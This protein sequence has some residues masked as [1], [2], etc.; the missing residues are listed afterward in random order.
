MSLEVVYNKV[1]LYPQNEAVLNLEE[2]SPSLWAQVSHFGLTINQYVFQYNK[3]RD[4][5]IEDQGNE[6]TNNL[7]RQIDNPRFAE[8]TDPESQANLFGMITE[9]DKEI[10]DAGLEDVSSSDWADLAIRLLDKPEKNKAMLGEKPINLTLLGAFSCAMIAGD[11]ATF[12]KF[13]H[14]LRET[15][16]V[17]ELSWSL[18]DCCFSYIYSPESENKTIRRYNFWSRSFDIT[19]DE[20]DLF[21]SYMASARQKER[22]TKPKLRQKQLLDGYQNGTV[23][24]ELRLAAM[25]DNQVNVGQMSQ[26]IDPFKTERFAL[27]QMFIKDQVEALFPEGKVEGSPFQRAMADKRGLGYEG[28]TS[29]A[30][31]ASD[32]IMELSDEIVTQYYVNFDE[33][34]SNPTRS[35]AATIRFREINQHTKNIKN[36]SR[37]L[38]SQRHSSFIAPVSQ[39]AL[40]TTSLVGAAVPN[41]TANYIQHIANM[42]QELVDTTDNEVTPEDLVNLALNKRRCITQASMHN[43]DDFRRMTT[44]GHFR[45]T[46]MDALSEGIKIDSDG[47]LE[48]TLPFEEPDIDR[49]NTEYTGP[50][51]G[52]PAGRIAVKNCLRSSEIDLKGANNLIDYVVQAMIAEAKARKI[53]AIA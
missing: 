49:K 12:I 24:E 37:L 2:I 15:K 19:K 32:S 44:K 31:A 33:P 53:F 43:I 11:E 34:I 16:Q 7:L 18:N 50:D 47:Q 17:K 40:W 20:I 42:G 46:T 27:Q 1:E 21:V 35:Q 36:F 9:I 8:E 51:L 52:C 38:A 5:G 13:A 22:R 14:K 48:L 30:E 26:D 6:L 28:F 10:K 39:L 41:V 45:L 23:T 4:M 25:H 3:L 29:L